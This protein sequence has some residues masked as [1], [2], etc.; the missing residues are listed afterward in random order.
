MYSKRPTSEITLLA[1]IRLP[2]Q[3]ESPPINNLPGGFGNGRECHGGSVALGADF[4]PATGDSL[5]FND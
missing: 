1:W 3:Q 5:R 2:S 4:I